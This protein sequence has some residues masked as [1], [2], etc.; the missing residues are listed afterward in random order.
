M[1]FASTIEGRTREGNRRRVFGTY[2]MVAGDT[3]G[4]VDVGMN[5]IIDFGFI[6]TD[7]TDARDAAK[8]FSTTGTSIVLTVPNGAVAA[9]SGKFFAVGN[10]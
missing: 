5:N 4:T 10:G 9:H 7:A 1:S 3:G 2:T 6:Q 8:R